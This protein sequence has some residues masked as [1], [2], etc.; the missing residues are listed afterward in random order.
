MRHHKTMAD[1]SDPTERLRQQI[2]QL[3]EQNRKLMEQQVASLE[4][5]S[6]W[7]PAMVAFLL[8]AT[9]GVLQVLFMAL[10]FLLLRG[11]A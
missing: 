11:L 2:Q 1:I 9:G 10:V 3:R 8:L 4:N 5:E 7:R 6:W